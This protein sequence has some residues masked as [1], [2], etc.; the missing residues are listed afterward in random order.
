MLQA[1]RDLREKQ[2][3]NVEINEISLAALRSDNRNF[4][5]IAVDGQVYKALLDPGAT[6]SLARSKVVERFIEKLGETST[7][8]RTATGNVTS[9]LGNLPFSIEIEAK[10]ERIIFRAIAELEQ[11]F[12][13]GMD[14]CRMFDIDARL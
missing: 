1:E 5:K 3:A 2:E 10:V 7:C 4:I 9:A 14:F 8:M 11:D 12:I 13:L 6:L